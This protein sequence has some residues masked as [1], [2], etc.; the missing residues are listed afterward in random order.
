MHVRTFRFDCARVFQKQCWLTCKFSFLIVID[1]FTCP[2]YMMKCDDGL[3]V[4]DYQRCDG[5]A[6]CRDG[7]DERDCREFYF[8]V[9]P[10]T[11]IIQSS[12]V[13]E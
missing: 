3:C 10:S 8:F 13:C 4:Y 6:N 9:R 7:S 2:D 11:L 1:D 5:R 12:S